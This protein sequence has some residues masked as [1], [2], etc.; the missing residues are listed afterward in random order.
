MRFGSILIFFSSGR[1]I[2]LKVTP[3]PPA[4]ISPS[5]PTLGVKNDK[6]K[7]CASQPRV[8]ETGTR[9]VDVQK[10]VVRVAK[11][12]LLFLFVF[13][14]TTFEYRIEQRSVGRKVLKDFSVLYLSYQYSS[15]FSSSCVNTMPRLC[16]NQHETLNIVALR[17]G[18]VGLGDCDGKFAKLGRSLGVRGRPRVV[19]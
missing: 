6:I 5:H 9:L 19:G 10:K 13:E 8:Y 7:K 18:G 14:N 3:G 16:D 15:V 12:P 11:K 17:R 1:Q 2:K 4:N